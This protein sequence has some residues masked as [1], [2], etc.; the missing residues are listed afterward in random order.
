MKKNISLI[1]ACMSSDMN[2]FKV[3]T[4][5]NNKKNRLIL[6]LII[7]IY[8]AFIIWFNSNMIF[9]KM[10]PLH[11]QAFV[12]SIFVFLISFMTIIEGIYKTGP[13]IFNCKDDQLLLSLPIK[14]RTVLFV[15]LFKFYI[16]ELIFNSIFIIPMMVAYIRWAETIDITYYITSIIM[17]LTLPIFPIIISCIIGVITSSITSRFKYKNFVQIVISLIVLVGVMLLSFNMNSVMDYLVK[18]A[19][20]LNDLI[21]KIYY[22]SGA[23]IKLITNFNIVD[24][25]IY[26][27]INILVSVISI[28]ILSKFYFKINSRLKKVTTTKTVNVNDLVIKSRSKRIAIIKKELNT[29]FKTPVFIVNSG[30]ALVLFI[31]AVILIS[32]KFDNVLPILT[33]K[34]SGLGLTKDFVY[35]NISVLILVLISITSFMTSI[36]SSVISLEGKNIS[37]L[38]SLPIKVKTILMSKIYAC[39]VITTPVL[40]IG[41]IVLFIRFNVGIIESILLLILSVLIPLVSHFIGILINLKYPKL[42]A[43]NSTEVVKQSTSSF[44]SVLLGMIL[45]ITTV[46][47]IFNIIDKFNSLTILIFAT[48]IYV[49]INLFLYLLLI[50]RGVKRFND[51]SV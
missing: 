29:F 35:N 9:E 34:K 1:K 8:L 48:I 17:I 3:S 46:M 41:N 36:T 5:K 42:D 16:F 47:I 33:D 12:L 32:V 14:R 38:K 15:R 37:I 21:E 51:L 50:K 39:L 26:I 28:L 24:L 2:V 7:M 13:L 10:S 6:P 20:S 43:E 11:L 30:F 25:I 19:S 31:L 49:I 44:F 27:L 18:N 22:P 40:V 4:K 23:Y 45:L